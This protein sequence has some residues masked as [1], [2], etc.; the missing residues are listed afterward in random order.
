MDKRYSSK[1][2]R[3]RKDYVY[4][5]VSKKKKVERL[6]EIPDKDAV[7]CNHD[8]VGPPSTG[9]LQLKNLPFDI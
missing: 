3:T 5:H 4:I 6:R 9:A 8:L 2:L 1:Y 7:E